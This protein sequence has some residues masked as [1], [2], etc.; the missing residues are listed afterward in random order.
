VKT[1]LMFSL[2]FIWIRTTDPD[3]IIIQ[4]NTVQSIKVDKVKENKTFKPFEDIAVSIVSVDKKQKTVT[5]G[6]KLYDTFPENT[7]Q[8]NQ[9]NAEYW[10]LVDLDNNKNTGGN[11]TMLMNI[12]VPV[13]NFIFNILLGRNQYISIL[14]VTNLLY[15]TIF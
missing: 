10:T 4:G 12:N 8:A 6:Q 9:S 13:T 11:K 3:N 15:Y 14:I 1:P 2:E 5:F 7:K